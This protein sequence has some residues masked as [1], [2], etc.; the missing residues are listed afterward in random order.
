MINKFKNWLGIE[1]VKA[2]LNIQEPLKRESGVLGAS[3][4]LHT[5]RDQKVDA[6]HIK[7]IEK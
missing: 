2:K 5:I 4:E 1:G 3:L 6:I 7:L